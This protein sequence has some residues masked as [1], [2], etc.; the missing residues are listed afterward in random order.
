[1]YISWRIDSLILWQ[2]KNE[3]ND[4][5]FYQTDRCLSMLFR[6]CSFSIAILQ[7]NRSWWIIRQTIEVYQFYQD[8]FTSKKSVEVIASCNMMIWWREWTHLKR[9]TIMLACFDWFS[10]DLLQAIM[11]IENNYNVSLH[12]DQC[13]LCQDLHVILF[14]TIMNR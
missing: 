1:M 10:S 11:I 8:D 7:P 9:A 12:R 6:I 5:W 4:R 14:L 2:S 3:K 13:D